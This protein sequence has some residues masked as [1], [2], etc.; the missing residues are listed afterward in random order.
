MATQPT[1]LPVPSESPRDLKFNAGKIDEFVTSMQREYEDRFGNKHYTIEGLRWIAQQAISAFG[2]ITLDSFEDGN[3]LTLPNQVLRLV[4]TGEYYR[5]DGALPKD[6]PPGSTPESTGGIGPGAWIGVGDASLRGELKSVIYETSYPANENIPEI[7]TTI[8]VSGRYIYRKGTTED[9]NGVSVIA[10]GDGARWK[11][12]PPE[13]IYA[14]DFCTDTPSLQN[15]YEIATGLGAKFY[16]DKVFENLAVSTTTPGLDPIVHAT[17]LRV[18]SNSHLEFINGGALKMATSQYGHY[19]LIFCVNGVKNFKIINAEIH[20]DRLTNQ[21]IYGPDPAEWGYGLTVYESENGEIINPK[22][23]NTIGDGIYIGK[24]WGDKT[25]SVPKNITITNPIIDGIRRNGISLGGA[26]NL[27]IYNPVISRVGDWDNIPGAYP[28]AG[29]DIEPE[30]AEDDPQPRIINCM[31]DNVS[32]TNCNYGITV[33]TVMQD[34][35]CNL[36]IRG[37]TILDGVL[38]GGI[39]MH[40]NNTGG[41]GK[42]SIDRVVFKSIP[43]FALNLAYGAKDNLLCEIGEVVDSAAGQSN[44]PFHIDYVGDMPTDTLSNISVRKLTS[45]KSKFTLTAQRDLSSMN[46]VFDLNMPENSEIDLAVAG[47]IPLSVSGKT[48]GQI[49]LTGFEYSKRRGDT[50]YISASSS[51]TYVSSQNDYR[52]LTIKK[53]VGDTNTYLIGVNGCRFNI[54][55]QL[56]GQASTRTPGGWIKI[57]NSNDPNGY[58]EIT[59][60]YGDWVFS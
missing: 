5:W 42:V 24:R 41:L 56:K 49:L 50:I 53:P 2:Y 8:M 37:S 26:E 3:T 51:D 22:I 52:E 9:V 58:T 4:A 31:I 20:G 32:I 40:R 18:P 55:G 29:I 14:S 38:N 59:G 28:K 21:H 36:D 19:N 34:L 10:S 12:L 7:Y 39:Y 13:A 16:I 47:N 60:I 43:Q 30:H 57:K 45:T 25:S 48:G 15:A 27:Q 17:I 44:I 6:V 1:N 35:V 23:Y 54:E 33:F 11:M 46:A